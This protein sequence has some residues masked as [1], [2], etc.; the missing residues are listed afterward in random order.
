[1]GPNK[2]N[3]IVLVYN[4]STFVPAT[5]TTQALP[6]GS[7]LH[8]ELDFDVACGEITVTADSFAGSAATPSANT[9]F[10]FLQFLTADITSLPISVSYAGDSPCTLAKLVATYSSPYT[11]DSLE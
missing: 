6:Q 7:F 10:N 8:Q 1:M 9:N 4:G 3:F 5:T 11:V 2:N